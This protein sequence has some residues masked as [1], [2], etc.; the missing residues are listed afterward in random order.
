MPSGNKFL[1]CLYHKEMEIIIDNLDE[2]Y[3][4]IKGL[5]IERVD[6]INW[7]TYYIDSITKEKWVEEHPFPEM[8]A[9]GPIQLRKLDYFPWE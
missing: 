9:G 2:V 4:K 1:N 3:D 5:K 6:D 8:Q 7:K